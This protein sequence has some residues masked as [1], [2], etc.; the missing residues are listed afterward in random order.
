MI[1]PSINLQDL[2]RKIY[3]KAKA[4]KSW[5]FWGMYVHVYKMETLQEA[6]R[7]VKRNRGAPGI[8]GVT[9][10]AIEEGGVDKYLQEIRNELIS[11]TYYPMRN[12]KLAIPKGNGRSRILSIPSIRL[13]VVKLILKANGKKASPKGA[14]SRH[15]SATSIS[16]R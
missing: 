4:E 2:R 12:R 1:K 7:L 13:R 6:Y 14:R 8:D 16:M 9:F 10:E 3:P 5:R 11:K 15:N